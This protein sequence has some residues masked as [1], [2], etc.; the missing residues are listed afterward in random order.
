MNER[1]LMASKQHD[2]LYY[3][4]KGIKYK[5][6]HGNVK[7]TFHFCLTKLED[8]WWGGFQYLLLYAHFTTPN[9]KLLKWLLSGYF[10]EGFL[11][12]QC[13]IESSITEMF[14]SPTQKTEY[15][16]FELQLE[17]FIFPPYTYDLLMLLLHTM[18]PFLISTSF[19][20][21]TMSI[22]KQIV[23]EK[24]AR[25]KVFKESGLFFWNVVNIRHFTNQFLGLNYDDDS[26]E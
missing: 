5:L 19:L 6:I 7:M 23:Q 18:M 22:T 12:L 8:M 14:L 2:S 24:S 10:D 4:K 1:T 11:Y 16:G 21:S 13:A 20:Y 9:V 26:Y 3:P 25:L 17:R 15:R